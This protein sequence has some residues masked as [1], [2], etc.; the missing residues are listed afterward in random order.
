MGKRKYGKCLWCETTIDNTNSD[1]EL[2]DI[3][4]T[5]P[6]MHEA[7]KHETKAERS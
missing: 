3:C 6:N 7:L 2:C 4:A 5:Y 1:R